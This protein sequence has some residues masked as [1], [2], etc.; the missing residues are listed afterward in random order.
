MQCEQ[1]LS[2]LPESKIQLFEGDCLD[3]MRGM[4]DNSIDFICCDP[5]YALTGKSGKGGFM[6]KEWDSSIPGV[7]IWKEAL[8][9]CK[10]GSMLAAFGGSRTHH[11]LM[12][13]LEQAGWAIRDVIMWLYGQG[14]NKGLNI[15]KHVSQFD[16]YNTSLKP[17]YEP[18][19]LCMK[20]LDGTFAQNALKWGVA[21]MNVDQC[22]V[23]VY[24][25]KRPSDILISKKEN[26]WASENIPYNISANH[27]VSTV[28]QK[29][30]EIKGCTATEN[31]NTM[32]LEQEIKSLTDINTTCTGCSV[33]PSKVA[34]ESS[35]SNM[36]KS[37]KMSMDQNQKDMS[38]TTS[39]TIPSITELKTCSLCPEEI[40]LATTNQ[41]TNQTKNE[42]QNTQKEKE[43]NEQ[44]SRYPS[45][46]ILDESSAELL[47]QQSGFSKPCKPCVGGIRKNGK[48][49]LLDFKKGSSPSYP[50]IRGD[51]GGASRFFFCAKASSS[52]RNKGL[53][54]MPLK[55]QVCYGEMK[56]TENHAPNRSN[57]VQNNHPCVKPLSLMRY[58]IKLL[59]PPG[60]PTCLDCFAGSGTTLLACKELGI[61]CI[62]IEK[63]PEYCEIIRKR[64]NIV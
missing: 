63:E 64:L 7:D 37:G 44:G 36:L 59:A 39:T 4:A 31:V 13:A 1:Q 17:S 27:V 46:I 41:N 48:K 58:I 11:H 28:K 62:G 14:F 43:N 47:D 54:G 6:G 57:K 19:I 29:T 23:P 60:N 15:G 12:I 22:R 21:G 34:N 30:L 56:G 45:N 61:D 8:R 16:G 42:K 53:E 50:V 18:I 2:L 25:Q 49:G 10:P 20:P 33:I 5:P 52:E 40:T 51:S 55:E 9:I 24:T 32:G 26:R 38:F 35:Y 3:V